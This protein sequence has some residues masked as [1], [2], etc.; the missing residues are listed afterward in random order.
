MGGMM[1]TTGSPDGPPMKAG[2]AV[3][4]F[5]AGTLLFGAVVSALYEREQSGIGSTVEVSMLEAVYPTLASPIGMHAAHHGTVPPRTGNRHSGLS[6][7]PYNTYPTTDGWIAI[8]C[9]R[10]EHWLNLLRAMEREDLLNDPRYSTNRARVARL[11]DVDAIVAAWTSTHTKDEIHRLTSY[12]KVPAGPIR[13]IAEVMNDPHMHE[14]SALQVVD[15]P[16]LGNV[17][18]PSAA[19]RFND[20]QP[21]A[22]RPS[23]RLG[24]D[25]DRVY[26]TWLGL[27]DESLSALRTQ[28]IIS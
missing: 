4:D 23:A 1:E 14:R 25:N 19:M 17:V 7:A 26:R 3:A 16:E 22:V 10:D 9:V 8:I 28:G 18:L 13:G 12:F 2:P 15:H 24:S 6:T 27:D 11:E 20:G 21:M 5:L